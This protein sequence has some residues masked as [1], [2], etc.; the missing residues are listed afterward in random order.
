MYEQIKLGRFAFYDTHDSK[1]KDSEV[2]QNNQNSLLA[3]RKTRYMY[4]HPWLLYYHSMLALS[5]S[6]GILLL[7]VTCLGITTLGIL[8]ISSWVL[9][10]RVRIALLWGWVSLGSCIWRWR[11]AVRGRWMRHVWKQHKHMLVI[12]LNFCVVVD[13]KQVF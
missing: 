13:N 2:T 11:L 3:I 7:G 10:V 6:I 8:S 12:Y 1:F 5:V 4:L 9:S